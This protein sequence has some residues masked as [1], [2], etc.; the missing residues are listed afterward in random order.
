MDTWQGAWIAATNL[1]SD[2]FSGHTAKLQAGAHI[3]YAYATDG[4]EATS[5]NTGLQSSPVISDITAY[6]FLVHVSVAALSP[7]SLSFPVLALS[8]T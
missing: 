5:T 1:G 8:S 4:Q 7:T 6:Q 2:K 3:L